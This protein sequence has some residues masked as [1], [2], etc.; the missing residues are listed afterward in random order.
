MGPR[1]I[2]FIFPLFRCFSPLMFPDSLQRIVWRTCSIKEQ[3]NDITL[4]RW[5][6]RERPKW[7]F[8]LRTL[9]VH[10]RRESTNDQCALTN[11]LVDRH[12]L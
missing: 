2:H 6:K 5:V 8:S 1:G 10:K 12:F 11:V 7:L 9:Y 3:Y 4:T